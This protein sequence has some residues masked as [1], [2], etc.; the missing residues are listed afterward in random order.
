[1][2]ENVQTTDTPQEVVESKP[3][4]KGSGCLIALGVLLVILVAIGGL[5]FW[6]YK[7]IVGLGS[8]INL[9]V[10]YSQQD[11]D[12]AWDKFGTEIDPA[13]ACL[14]CPTLTYTD[15]KEVSTT[16]NNSEASAVVDIINENLEYGSISNSQVRFNDD[17]TAELST[18]FSFQ[19]QTFPVYLS[20]TFGKQT[21]SSVFGSVSTV[22][23]GG[24]SLPGNITEIVGSA[25]VEIA[26]TRIVDAGVRIDTL[27]ITG[28]GLNFDGLVP[29]QAQ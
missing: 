3:K 15:H 29:T 10:T 5:L 4:K 14:D 22:K 26:N 6:G 11:F 8:Q 9:D 7:K 28:S 23:A 19:G 12:S 25:L 21:D 1:M 18:V 13:I 2:E 24:I 20:G 27:D 16:F 17:G